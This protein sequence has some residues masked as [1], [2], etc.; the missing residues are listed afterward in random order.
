MPPRRVQLL[1]RNEAKVLARRSD[2]IEG[3]GDAGPK[4][5]IKWLRKGDMPAGKEYTNPT[6]NAN[7]VSGWCA[8]DGAHPQPGVGTNKYIP[9]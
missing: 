8:L 3:Y 9:I 6:A 2:V 5:T 7:G 4:R 1:T